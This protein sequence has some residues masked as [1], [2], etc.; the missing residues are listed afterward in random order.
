MPR[1]FG[2]NLVAVLVSGVSFWLL[3]Y[4]FYGVLF[5]EPW[6]AAWGISEAD[7]AATADGAAIGMAIGFLLSIF[8]AFM[9]GFALKF[10]KADDMM[11]ALKK[12]GFLWIGFALPTLAYD[13][14]YAM[15]PLYLLAID[16][17]HLLVGYLLIAAVQRLFK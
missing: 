8:T 2:L 17:G 10:L 13:T 16:A 6:R 7:V 14:I 4:L 3:G 12:A 9:I 11:S 15:Q 1:V 5:M